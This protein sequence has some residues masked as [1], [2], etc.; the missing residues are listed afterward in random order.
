M[1]VTSCGEVASFSNRP[2]KTSSIPKYVSVFCYVFVDWSLWCPVNLLIRKLVSTVAIGIGCSQ[3]IY[4]FA[5]YVGPWRYSFIKQK[6]VL[7]F[8]DILCTFSVVN[9]MN[10]LLMVQ[11]SIMSI[12]KFCVIISVLTTILSDTKFLLNNV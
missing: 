11:E 2:S 12:V 8:R 10:T 4:S 9:W 3:N 6:E 1:P 7:F 5:N